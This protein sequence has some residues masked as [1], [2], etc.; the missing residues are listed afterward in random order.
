MACLHI[1]FEIE[2]AAPAACPSLDQRQ[3]GVPSIPK[4][5]GVLAD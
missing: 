2:L 3:R 5:H 1:C 4:P